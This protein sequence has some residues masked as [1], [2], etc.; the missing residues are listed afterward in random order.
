MSFTRPCTLRASELLSSRTE[1]SL[2]K[3]YS[4]GSWRTAYVTN[5][6]ER[7]ESTTDTAT[8]PRGAR[9]STAANTSA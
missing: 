2:L 7:S 9:S 4:K 3:S 8:T 5:T 6:T 1:R